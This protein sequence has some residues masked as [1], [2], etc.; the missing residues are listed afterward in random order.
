MVQVGSICSEVVDNQAG[1]ASHKVV[2]EMATFSFS[3]A[4]PDRFAREECADLTD[5]M[6]RGTTNVSFQQAGAPP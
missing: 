6:L 4:W 1:R 5:P 2:A 3:R